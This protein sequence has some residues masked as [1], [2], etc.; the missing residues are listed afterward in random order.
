M[1]VPAGFGME[2]MQALNPGKSVMG[3]SIGHPILYTSK[4]ALTYGGP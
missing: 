2:P 4:R 3:S 1:R